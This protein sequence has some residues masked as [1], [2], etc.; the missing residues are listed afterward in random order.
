MQRHKFKVDSL[1]KRPN[2]PILLQRRSI[3]A[4]QLV[5]G[6]RSLH[7]R[8]TAQENEEIRAC[9]DCLICGDPSDDFEVFVLENDFVLEELEPCGCCWA[10][11]SY[12]GAVSSVWSL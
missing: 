6:T 3:C 11:N 7:N 4:L 5:F 1:H 9:E 2:H 10:E 12:W 8:H